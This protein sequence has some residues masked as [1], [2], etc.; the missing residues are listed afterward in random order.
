M[1]IKQ[2]TDVHI[3]K[4]VIDSLRQRRAASSND[5]FDNH[6]ERMLDPKDRSALA[7]VAFH[8]GNPVA[9][10]GGYY[11]K[12]DMLGYFTYEVKFIICLNDDNRLMNGIS[13]LQLSRALK[14]ITAKA[15]AL[16]FRFS[17]YGDQVRLLQMLKKHMGMKIADVTMEVSNG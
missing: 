9:V 13:V 11:L 6:M 2:A 14:E 12:H 10:A 1:L 15:G 8:R 7:L 4:T 5:E 17:L 3:V 16:T